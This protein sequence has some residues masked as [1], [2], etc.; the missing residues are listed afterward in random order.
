MAEEEEEKDSTKMTS[1][2]DK[3]IFTS[4]TPRDVVRGWNDRRKSN[5]QV[6]SSMT[7]FVQLIGIFNPDEYEK[8]FMATDE[9]GNAV[10]RRAV[11]Y[12]D[13]GQGDE[14]A[15][16]S[17]NSDA[18]KESSQRMID[19]IKEKL[20]SRFINL[21][22]AQ[23]GGT[24]ENSF[25][26]VTPQDGIIMAEAISQTK[27]FTGGIGI[28]D[29]QVDAGK[30]AKSLTM[31]LTVNDP[32]LLNE[33]PE[34][35]KMSTLQ[36]EFLV[37]YGWANPRIVEGFDNSAPPR[38]EVDP[39]DPTG[40]GMMRIP[41]G[42][43]DTGGYWAA[44][45]MNIT[46]YDFAFN[47]M[48]Q[49][50]VTL[51]LMNQTN[52]YLAT[53]R[54]SAI[55]NTWRKIMG[56]YDFDSSNPGTGAGGFAGLRLTDPEGNTK[57]LAQ[58]A[59]EEQNS[60]NTASSES[61]VW[62]MTQ[63]YSLADMGSQLEDNQSLYDALSALGAETIP[64][65]GDAG[66][67][68]VEELIAQ[69]KVTES[70]G[71]PHS[72]GI[73]MYEK[74]TRYVPVEVDGDVV[75][76]YG[77]AADDDPE[78]QDDEE[79]GDQGEEITATVV[80][81]PV[82]GYRTKAVYYYLGWVMDGIKLSLS[83]M[84]R[85]ASLTNSR[86]IIPKFSYLA[87]SSDSNL[88][89]AFQSQ[90]R[91]S[92]NTGINERIQNAII[93]L[94]EKC[95]P[96]WAGSR[97]SMS[98]NSLLGVGLGLLYG[99][100]PSPCRGQAV[101]DG[102]QTATTRSLAAALFPTP[103]GAPVELPYRGFIVT[104]NFADES[105]TTAAYL[106][107]IED[108]DDK[109]GTDIK[110]YVDRKIALSKT[111]TTVMTGG[112]Q[113]V[114]GRQVKGVQRQQTIYNTAEAIFR[115]FK[116]D[117]YQATEPDA[118]GSPVPTGGSLEGYDPF[119]PTLYKA[120]DR[121]GR[122][123]YLVSFTHKAQLDAG[124]YTQDHQKIVEVDAYRQSSPELWSLTQRKW[125]NMY[126]TYLGNYFEAVIRK[127]MDELEVEGKTVEDIY[128]EPVDLDFLTG[129][130]YRNFRFM[131][132]NNNRWGGTAINTN[133]PD[134]PVIKELPVDED[135][136]ETISRAQDRTPSLNEQR[137]D[138]QDLQF[139]LDMVIRSKLGTIKSLQSVEGTSIV[140][141][142]DAGIEQLTGG[143][144]SRVSYND[145]GELNQNVQMNTPYMRPG[146]QDMWGAMIT[147]STYGYDGDP[148]GVDAA[149][150]LI[151]SGFNNFHRN[152]RGD[153]INYFDQYETVIEL[154][155]SSKTQTPEV[156]KEYIMYIFFGHRTDNFKQ[157]DT[158]EGGEQSRF[159]STSTDQQKATLE[160]MVEETQRHVNRKLAQ[161]VRINSELEPLY[162]QYERHNQTIE[163]IDRQLADIERNLETYT[164]FMTEDG[165][166][167]PLSLYE[168]T[169][170]F[171]D[172]LEI[173]MGREQPMR[174][175]TKVAQQWYR[176]FGDITQRGAG[177]VTNYG[178]AKGG[179]TYFPPSN[180]KAFR[181][182]PA[183][184]GKDI[185]GF[186][187][188][189]LDPA[190]YEK[191][192]N[193][194]RRN[195]DLDLSE[196]STQFW[197]SESTGT[198]YNNWGLFGTPVVPDSAEAQ[199]ANSYGFIQGPKI[200]EYD[201][202]GKV[203]S[204]AGGSYV[205][206][207]QDFLNL[208]NVESNPDLP[209]EFTIR[210]TWPNRYV[211]GV[212]PYYMIDEANNIIVPGTGEREGWFEQSGWFLGDGGFP[213]YLYPSREMATQIDP[214]N[215]TAAMPYGTPTG[216]YG[217]T[218]DG[219]PI[220]G[221][222]DGR[223][224]GEGGSHYYEKNNSGERN[225]LLH[226]L[227]RRFDVRDGRP[228]TT[229]TKSH[230]EG[231]TT[232]ERPDHLGV[233]KP[234]TPYMNIGTP[235]NPELSNIYTI[236][237]L[238]RLPVKSSEGDFSSYG[239]RIGRG[240]HC[241]NLTIDM[242]RALVVKRKNWYM[243]PLR[244]GD[245]QKCF[246]SLGDDDPAAHSGSPGS[247][248][249][250]KIDWNRLTYEVNIRGEKKVFDFRVMKNDQFAGTSDM[251]PVYAPAGSNIPSLAAYEP[252]IVNDRMVIVERVNKEGVVSSYPS[253]R[254]IRGARVK[255]PQIAKTK[256]YT[257]QYYPYGTGQYQEGIMQYGSASFPEKSPN[258]SW[259]YIGDFLDRLPGK[260]FFTR[261]N[262][263]NYSP[264]TMN[265]DGT[266]ENGEELNMGFIKFVVQNVL[267]PLPKNR[268]IGSRSGDAIPRGKIE[269]INARWMG[270]HDEWRLQDV[271]YGHLFRPEDEDKEDLSGT[272]RSMADLSNLVI[273]NA[274]DIPIRRDVI[275][276]LMN[277][278]NSNMSISQFIQ[279]IMRPESIGV[280]G[281]N[282]NVGMR[283]RSD[284]VMEV[285]Q[286][287]KNWRNVA[288]EMTAETED[289][290][291]KNRYPAGHL[292]FDYKANDSLIERIDMNSKFDPG[293]SMTFELG[294]RAFAGNPD[295][296]AQFLSFGNVA[297]ELKVFLQAE[298]NLDDTEITE[299]IDVAEGDSGEAGRV[300]FA[301]KA[302]FNE[303]AEGDQKT[304]PVNIVTKFLMQNPER[305]AKLNAMLGAEPGS[306]FATQL[307]SNY[308]RKTTITIHGTTNIIPYN[309]IYVRG[310]LPELEGMYLVTNV[311]E[312]ITT[313]GFQ[314]II[315]AT[316]IQ[317]LAVDPVT[318]E[319]ESTDHG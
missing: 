34:Y 105:A 20:E 200:E 112:N 284:G 150:N 3:N 266:I 2:G 260:G 208:F 146:Q 9:E 290:L 209:G 50:E 24:D 294:A 65:T 107:L 230:M 291:L 116:P 205:K 57:T 201:D 247:A 255:G 30:G 12:T 48:G 299:I 103:A 232:D 98:Q 252:V 121:G 268:R 66:D 238:N 32:K 245:G 81:K 171:D 6:I 83:D 292:L 281:K 79:G 269:V 272:D 27:D 16:A 312:S 214:T 96:P 223:D 295:K 213:I 190:E 311:R 217:L 274:G 298:M 182:D 36:G 63:T 164:R 131:Y 43:I 310:V 133:I 52:M 56:T 210:G 91:R 104:I 264:T 144:Y 151:Y 85:G 31:R 234:G 226:Q 137:S 304:V 125:H 293:L 99:F 256:G 249:A 251:E 11:S 191:N 289:A 237:L 154:D 318:G 102:E 220:M 187:K 29:L 147:R 143:R 239:S 271:T 179:T 180:T 174:L 7:P 44:E 35:S 211:Q 73:S 259:L 72:P 203:V 189:I 110:G 128:D 231:W 21:Y 54:L 161:I 123:Y 158:D 297:K 184:V 141:G 26:A 126:I 100:K 130:Q 198:I 132:N 262:N 225:H 148:T 41:I 229:L 42:A 23:G 62:G 74:I 315:E 87:N 67:Q 138:T 278:Q 37:I 221:H 195:Y 215:T 316:L 22:I 302:F 204:V 285:F 258:K 1:M 243:P 178:P 113:T 155:N 51:K 64:Y 149:R 97:L 250:V 122:F 175:E 142:E 169:S 159:E 193:N 270:D 124:G 176:M 111:T 276:N 39:T 40:N 313:S 319:T 228:A 235:L 233:G 166:Q 286:A 53:T 283:Q 75:A 275:D 206:D 280:N 84:N 5:N 218:S 163:S 129:K 108:Y 162:L 219:S 244:Q 86:K 202:E 134:L 117:W 305:M 114:S 172:T 55:S 242:K 13:V 140:D 14:D 136:L 261:V 19:H 253:L 160:T 49:L 303:G 307:L 287:S 135:L 18:S 45:R 76:G 168:D 80:T 89:T 236:G 257:N 173:D 70:L 248:G 263:K 153:Y 139:R 95:M 183:K 17:L 224:D 222:R 71:Y 88:T 8:M 118:D 33:N 69:K 241:M 192:E 90:V 170:E 165:K 314:T 267:A 308:M 301:K 185:V 61:G 46:G 93:R 4:Q 109:N 152:I 106:Q 317:N 254:P 115:F 288:R 282:V 196:D 25:L 300:R 216:E 194:G 47:E 58:L 77:D 157:N 59:Q 246:W 167:K 181:K 28:T 306:N 119:N 309:T 38:L 212:D 60:Y 273:D 145:N 10:A 156:S 82:T 227:G 199:S 15:L 68:Q 120:A 279:E 296:F 78:K 277:K 188:A 92:N 177:D 94:K 101:C 127:R 265:P 186:P 197:T 207:Y 240:E